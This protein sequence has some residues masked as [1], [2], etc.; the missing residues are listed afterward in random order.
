[1]TAAGAKGDVT[2]E[3]AT[4][5]QQAVARRAAESKATVP[6][7]VLHAEAEL[8][9]GGDDA[10]TLARVVKAA[11]SALRLV[12]RANGAYRDGG[13]ERYSRIN[14]AIG[15]AAQDALLAPTVFDADSKSPAEIAE[16]VE[17]LTARAREGS[18][19]APDLAG[20]T[21]TVYELPWHGVRSFVPV[22]PPGQAVCVAIGA[23]R[24][25]TLA[26]TVVCDH[27]IVYGA[28]AGEF[29]AALCRALED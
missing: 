26:L 27:R 10:P 2:R 7:L 8:A 18:L 28:T 29:V 4:R 20:A 14:I 9:S 15:L 24:G 25:Q 21:F 3:E 6:H 5:L 1:M 22:L 13:F 23:R 17:A 11:A 19:T 16:A 12:P